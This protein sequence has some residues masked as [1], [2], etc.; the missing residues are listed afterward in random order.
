MS[1]VYIFII[2]AIVAFFVLN[3]VFKWDKDKRE[4]YV[5]ICS[6]IIVA[7]S[8]VSCERMLFS[9][10]DNPKYG[11]NDNDGY[12]NGFEEEHGTDPNEYDWN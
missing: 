9:D 12:Q 1:I 4:A 11:D 5:V 8:F 3:K 10:W 2:I 6:L 7:I